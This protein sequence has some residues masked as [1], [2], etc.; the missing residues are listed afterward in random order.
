MPQILKDLEQKKVIEYGNN[1]KWQLTVQILQV[2]VVS[3]N[4]RTLLTFAFFEAANH[5]LENRSLGQRV[6][7]FMVCDLCLVDFD[8]FCV[9]CAWSFVHFVA[10]DRN[11]DWQQIAIVNSSFEIPAEFTRYWKA[12][13][14]V[15]Q[16]KLIRRKTFCSLIVT[17]SIHLFVP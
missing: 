3:N 11:Y 1:Q 15:W 6:Q 2:N 17:Y 4:T 14:T 12:Q 13:E 16:I 5:L 9:C 7:T 8:S 10:C